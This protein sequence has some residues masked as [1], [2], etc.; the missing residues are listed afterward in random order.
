MVCGL[1]FV[2]CCC[3][4]RACC[5]ASRQGTNVCV[6]CSRCFGRVFFF[7]RRGG[8]FLFPLFPL[9]AVRRHSTGGASPPSLR[10]RLHFFQSKCCSCLVPSFDGS[11]LNICRV[12][13]APSSLHI[14]VRLREGLP[15]CFFCFY[16]A[17]FPRLVVQHGACACRFAIPLFSR[18]VYAKLASGRVWFFRP[19]RSNTFFSCL[20]RR[21]SRRA[22]TGHG[23]GRRRHGFPCGRRRF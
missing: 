6:L 8:V 18:Y 2:V 14:F 23:H 11:T 3:D 19:A 21:R 12:L 1:W 5:R 22:G 4:A 13:V 10:T 20:P 15:A 16:L 17:L 9:S 7:S